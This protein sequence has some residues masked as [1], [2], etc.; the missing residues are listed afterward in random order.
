VNSSS[1]LRDTGPRAV[2][3]TVVLRAWVLIGTLS[4]VAL[5]IV[6]ARA[7]ARGS[8]GSVHVEIAGLVGGARP[9]VILKGPGGFRRALSR[10]QT[11]SDLRDGR[12]VLHAKSAMLTRPANA[13]PAGSLMLPFATAITVDVRSGKTAIVSVRYATI[14]RK[15][16]GSLTEPPIRVLGAANDPSGLLVGRSRAPRVGQILSQAPSPTLPGGLFDAVTGVTATGGEDRIS[17]RPA[18]L[19]EAFPRLA[20]NTTVPLHLAIQP[21]ASDALLQS[22]FAR[23]ADIPG[24]DFSLGTGPVSCGLVTGSLSPALQITASYPLN[25]SLRVVLSAKGSLNLDLASPAGMTC[26]YTFD[27][28]TFQGVV[29]I[30]TIPVPVY[31]SLELEVAGTLKAASNAGVGLSMSAEGGL[32]YQHGQTTPIFNAS[33]QGHAQVGCLSGDVQFLPTL[34]AGIGLKDPLAANV[35][36]DL[37][38]G[39]ELVPT[40][41]GWKTDALLQLTAGASLGPITATLTPALI[42]HHYGSWTG[43]NSGCSGGGGNGKPPA[44]AGSGTPGQP[45]PTGT[46]SAIATGVGF[47]CAVVNGGEVYC[48]GY[49]ERGELGDGTT[50]R[51]TTAIRVNGITNATAVAAGGTTV[52]AVLT[53]GQLDCWG[54]GAE[55]QMG[56]GTTP[57]VNPLPVAVGDLSNAIGVSVGIED[58]CAVLAT[59]EI[60]CWGGNGDGDL[61]I[62]NGEPSLQPAPV[63]GITDAV[64]VST[65]E[66]DSC[67]LLATARV[68]CWGDNNAGQLGF[69]S[70]DH[71]IHTWSPFRVEGISEATSVSVGGSEA[72]AGLAPG[73]ADCWGD[74][75]GGKLGRGTPGDLEEHPTPA[76]VVDLA[77][78]KTV[79]VGAEQACALLMT[80]RIDCW[81]EG[82]SGELGDGELTASSVPVGVVGITNATGLA[83][84]FLSSCALISS[85]EVE[86]WPE[87]GD[88]PVAVSGL[89]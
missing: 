1:S 86:C 18:T 24:V 20:L 39:P 76:P 4:L 43:A 72:C 41:S 49:N 56:N 14:I 38:F 59:G 68:D 6:P 85:G 73:T 27:G 21:Q 29:P 77:E 16:V 87:D 42:E 61:G 17:L 11:L 28:P 25:P 47:G 30:G 74:N 82:G 81:G 35:H 15:G 45:P 37:S 58:V 88:T 69:P 34:E 12:Y 57:E 36:A 66:F 67:A 46:A 48:W 23:A 40:A 26:S 89:P 53:T 55:G 5:L 54:N 65:A 83:T 78:V 32:S 71:T 19:S 80:G 60:K 10:S 52:C 2:G 7:Q 84:D 79:A 64:S 8:R 9:N 63:V 33:V 70:S 62:G 22:P 44:G 51:S 13:A 75:S 31:G 50:S 3:T